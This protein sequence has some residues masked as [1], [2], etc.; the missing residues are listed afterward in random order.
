LDPDHRVVW[1]LRELEGLDTEAIARALHLKAGTVRSRLFTARHR[2]FEA[3]AEEV[4]GA[5]VIPIRRSG[6]R[7]P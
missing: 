1:L 4:E 7:R 3:V 6:R 5:D 2:V